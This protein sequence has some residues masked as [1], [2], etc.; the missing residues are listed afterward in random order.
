MNVP[1]KK[2]SLWK[3]IFFLRLSTGAV[4][5]DKQ[6][7]YTHRPY[8]DMLYMAIVIDTVIFHSYFNTTPVVQ[9]TCRSSFDGLYQYKESQSSTNC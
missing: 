4:L 5:R 9:A 7:Q 2:N 6:H 8:H 3:H 1:K